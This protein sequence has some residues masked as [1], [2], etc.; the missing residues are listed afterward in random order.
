MDI[1]IYPGDTTQQKKEKKEIAKLA[2]NNKEIDLISNAYNYIPSHNKKIK[3]SD[4]AKAYLDNYTKRDKAMIDTTIK[5]F[6]TF[7]N[8]SNLKLNAID[9]RC[10]WITKII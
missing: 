6:K 5:Q 8:N 2:R 10:F 3:F 9:K 4:Y 7:P 1:K